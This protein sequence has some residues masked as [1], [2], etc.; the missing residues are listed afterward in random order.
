MEALVNGLRYGSNRPGVTDNAHKWGA[1]EQ[2]LRCS[3]VRF[4]SQGT[5]YAAAANQNLLTCGIQAEYAVFS[6]REAPVAG[7]YVAVLRQLSSSSGR[8]L[9]TAS[10]ATVSVSSISETFF[11]SIP[12]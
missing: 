4:L 7:V 12:R 8:C 2:R 3:P 5:D 11:P 10:A 9:I 1:V 6:H